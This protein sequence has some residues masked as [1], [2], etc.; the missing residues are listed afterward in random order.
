MV[1]KNAT[2]LKP[3]LVTACRIL[4]NE[5]ITDEL[6]HISVRVPGTDKVFINGRVSPGQVTLQDITTVDLNGKHL[7]GRQKAPGEMHLHLSIY[8]KRQEVCA[9]A[10]THSPMVVILSTLGIKLR[11]TCHAAAMAFSEELPMYEKYGMISSESLGDEV[12][13]LLGGAPA[14]MLKGHGIIVVGSSLQEC[15]IRAFYIEKAAGIQYNAL[16]IGEPD[17]MPPQPPG[18]FDKA[19]AGAIERSWNY[20]QWKIRRK[21]VSSGTAR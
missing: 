11:P 20:F 2:R 9:V 19:R 17:V 8:K 15:C 4:D 21:N 1:D 7:H 10:H 3:L 14:I 6:G 12:A 13:D 16:V 18:E 5:K